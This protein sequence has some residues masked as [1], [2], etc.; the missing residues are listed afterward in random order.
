MPI[1]L[2]HWILSEIYACATSPSIAAIR[3]RASE[4]GFGHPAF[5]MP[6]WPAEVTSATGLSIT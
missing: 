3:R 4:A 1:E 6:K 5:P 2:I